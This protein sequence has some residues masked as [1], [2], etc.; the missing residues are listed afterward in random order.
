MALG[1]SG[2]AWF[3]ARALPFALEARHTDGAP[4]RA[5]LRDASAR[6]L[7]GEAEFRAHLLYA[8][9]HVSEFL[10]T[11]PARRLAEPAVR[12]KT[13]FFRGGEGEASAHAGGHIVWLFDKVAFHIDDADTDVF[14]L[15]GDVADDFD[16][17]KLTAGHFEV[18][19]VDGEVVEGWVERR[20]LAWGHGARFVISEAQVGRQSCPADGRLY[21]AVKNFNE[22]GWILFVSVAAHGGFIDGDFLASGVDEVGQFLSDDG[23]Q[24]FGEGPAVGVL[25]IGQQAT[26]EGVRSGDRCFQN[27]GRGAARLRLSGDEA[28]Q[29]PEFVD[30]AQPP[31]RE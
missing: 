16:F 1:I 13:Q 28:P 11:G 7:S 6:A 19:F 22:T 27:R 5:T 21:R 17:R 18:H 23:Q 2:K 20:V 8:S 15:F 10:A 26:G 4:P 31:G 30:D 3:V 14:S 25:G 29:P 24:R 12:G 9:D